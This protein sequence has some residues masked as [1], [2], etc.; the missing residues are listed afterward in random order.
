M[1]GSINW[2]DCARVGMRRVGGLSASY[3][4]DLLFSGGTVEYQNLPPVGENSD[5]SWKLQAQCKTEPI[6]QE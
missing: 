1:W 3:A 5:I 4:S 2:M 6:C